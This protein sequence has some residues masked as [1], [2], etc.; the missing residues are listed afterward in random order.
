LV[1]RD[2]QSLQSGYNLEIQEQSN[3]KLLQ[4]L[5]SFFQSNIDP[6]DPICASQQRFAIA[7][8]ACGGLW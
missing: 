4:R 1:L 2:T 6:N 7:A 3:V 5:K 8:I